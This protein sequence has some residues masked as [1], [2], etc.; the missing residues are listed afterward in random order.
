MRPTVHR[1]LL[2]TSKRGVLSRLALI[3][4]VLALVG[5][6]ARC[7]QPTGSTSIPPDATGSI[8]PAVTGTPA[9][10]A[11]AATSYPLTLVGDDDTK[12][13]IPSEPQKIVS[14]TPATTE[15]LF[16]IGAGD[17]LVGKV[18]D[19]ANYPPEAAEL[20][21][22]GTFSGIDVERIVGMDAD[23]VIAGGSNGT[24]VE[25]I[26]KLRSL[27]IPVLVVYAPDVEG[28]F[29]DIEL[30]GE[31]VGA[32]GPAKD[33]A[34]SMR[35]GFDKVARATASLDKPRVFYETGDDPA[36]FGVADRSFVASMIELAGAKVITTGSST[37]W[38]MSIERLVDRDP[39]IIILG[40]AA[41]GVTPDAIK[42]RAGWA[43]LTAVKRDAI[44][45]VDDIIVTRPGP[46]LLDGL[47]T[48]VGAIHPDA[49]LPEASASSEPSPAASGQG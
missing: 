33:L 32:A 22:V 43:G 48:L 41:Y 49:E 5:L 36:I 20:P 29:K 25:A 18:G 6:V 47:R 34:A 45:P 39:E 40:D 19:P 11:S 28:V 30:T 23:L 8:L 13:E 35:A 44:E 9:A 42:K 37:N 17:R 14:L 26:D 1:P 7:N 3:P 46:R 4:V 10:S 12:V 24:P 16:A 21:V 15:I 27:R 38:E 2:R 31:A